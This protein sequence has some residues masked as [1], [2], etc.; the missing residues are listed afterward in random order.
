MT[1]ESLDQYIIEI[2]LDNVVRVLIELVVAVFLLVWCLRARREGA[3]A[4]GAA[5]A[6]LGWACATALYLLADLS[7]WGAPEWMATFVWDHAAAIDWIRVASVA[8]VVAAVTVARRAPR[9]D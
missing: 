2:P 5:V 3:W 8:G 7:I 6:A 4:L 1:K 9:A